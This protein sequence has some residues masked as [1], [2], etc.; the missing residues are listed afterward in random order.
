MKT[1][2]NTTNIVKTFMQMVSVSSESG[3]EDLFANF[4]L[5]LGRKMGGSTKTDKF[6]NVYISFKGENE[7]IMLNTHMD[8][9][10]PG[11]GIKPKVLGKFIVSDGKTVLGADSKAGIAA[12]IEAVN[13]VKKNKI[14]HRKVEITLT[15]N[16]E[17]GIPTAGKINSKIK[18]CVV[19]DRG[20][21]I[22][23]VITQA[24][25]DQVFQVD[26]KGKTAYGP[27]SYKEGIHA[28]DSAVSMLNAL[29]T[30]NI[31]KYTTVNIGI[32]NGGEMTSMVAENCMFKGSCYSFSKKS[33]DRFLKRLK[34]VVLESDRKFKTKSKITFLEYFG[35]FKIKKTDTLVKQVENAMTQ[36]GIKPKHKVYKAVSNANLLNQIGIKSVLISTGVENQ[37]TTRERIAIDTLEKLTRIMINLITV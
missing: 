20:T 8:T 16:E 9:V 31:D 32:L 2:I 6:G 30:G 29:P 17:S 10:G 11:V 34:A 12:M 26:I 4:M 27:T 23:E 37:H 3:N 1:K 13:F 7:A 19:P 25:Y 15:R 14:P 28:I 24:P 21:P 33:L 5:S 18:E 36:A 35:G 22:G